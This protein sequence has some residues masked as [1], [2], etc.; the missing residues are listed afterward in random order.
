MEKISR[1]VDYP[2]K[3]DL[4]GV[5]VTKGSTKYLLYAVIVHEGN[6]LSK[7][8]YICFIKC[9]TKKW[10]K[11]SDESVEEVSQDTVRN[12]KAYMLFYKCS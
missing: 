1:H 5:C 4:S 8:H 7:G 3:L 11:C 10:F 12:Q 9:G 2:G 6:T